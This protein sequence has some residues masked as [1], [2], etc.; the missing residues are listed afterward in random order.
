MTSSPLLL[1][2]LPL[3]VAAVPALLMT[4]HGWREIL[5]GVG[6]LGLGLSAWADAVD[7]CGACAE[8]DPLLLSGAWAISAALALIGGAAL[9]ARRS[10][11]IAP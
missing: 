4:D 6:L 10:R 9:A 8:D 1:L 5:G 3:L 7:N 11:G 2:V